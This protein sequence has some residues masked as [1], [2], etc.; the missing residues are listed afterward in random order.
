MADRTVP[1]AMWLQKR[2]RTLSFWLLALLVA[3]SIG[4]LLAAREAHAVSTFTVNQTG[5]QADA[6]LNDNVCDTNLHTLPRGLQ[7]SFEGGH[8]GGQRHP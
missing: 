1:E 6:N 7:C 3:A 5:D 8:P 2:A 4:L